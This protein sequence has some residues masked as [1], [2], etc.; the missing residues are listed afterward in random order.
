M[1]API[2]RASGSRFE[3]DSCLPQRAAIESGKVGFRALSHGH[4]PGTPLPEEVLGGVS[5]MGFFD[6]VSE[7]DWGIGDHRNEGVELCFQ[8]TGSSVL[9]VDGCR[10]ELSP[11]TLSITR[12]WQ[13]HRLGDPHLRPGRLHWIILDVG[14]RRPNQSWRWP[15]WCVLSPAD[16]GELTAALRGN[17]HPVWPAGR[18]IA[19]GFRRLGGWIADPRPASQVSR[20][21]VGLN[22]L[23]VAL[24]DLLRHQ[25]S[26]IDPGL[27][28]RRRTVELFLRE[29]RRGGRMQR[30]AWSL[31]KMAEHC[32][33]GRTSFAAHCR[34]LTN[35][36]PIG[37]LNHCRLDRAERMLR[38]EPEL[39]VAEVAARCGFASS[40]YFSR[41]FA[42]RRGMPPGLWRHRTAAG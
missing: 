20:L 25:V 9:T 8:E 13:L 5:S 29:L 7:Q 40:Q 1:E 28:S 38:D 33:M 39:P 36:T 12:P 10:H 35:E 37:Y 16:R 2:Y 32:G 31:P 14:V 23:L 4:Y 27:S 3:V 17:G 42:A 26:E 6:L 21:T 22:Q 24:L 34:E 18:E 19:E 30:Q 41:K 11:G 15:G